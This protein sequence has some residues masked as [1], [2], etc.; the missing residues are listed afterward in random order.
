LSAVGGTLDRTARAV[1]DAGGELRAAWSPGGWIAVG[2]LAVAALVPLALPSS[3]RIDGLADTGYL[4]LAAVGLG[5]A[6]GIGGIP[7]LAQGAFVGVGAVTAAHAVESGWPALGAAV[8]GAAVAGAGG[9]LVGI[10]LVRFRAAYVVAATWLVTWLFSLALDAFPSV[11]GGARGLVVSAKPILGFTPTPT[12][13]YELALGLLVLALLGHWTLARSSF[14][15]SL[16]AAAQRPAAAAALGVAIARLGLAAFAGAAAVGGLAGGLAV[17]LAAVADPD[18][19]GPELSFRLLVAVLV[20]GAATAL[21]PVAGVLVLG[22]LSL[23]ADALADVT[24]AETAR[25]GPMLAAL[26]LVAV[27]TIGSDGIV[28]AAARLRQRRRTSPGPRADPTPVEGAEVAARGLAKRFGGVVALRSFDLDLRTGRIAALIGPNGSGKTTALRLLAGTLSPD[29]GSVSLDRVD[30]TGAP[31]AE[32]ARR[33]LV[34]TLQAGAVFPELTAL[35]NAVVGASLRRRHGGPLR[36]LL[37]TPK[38]REEARLTR[39]R[40]LAALAAVELESRADEPAGRLSGAEQRLLMIASALAT[41]PRVLLVDEPSAGAGPPDLERLARVFRR[42]RHDGLAVLV[43]EHNL[44][45]VRA[46]A[47]EVVVLD[48]GVVL[49]TAAPDEIARDR[50][51]RAAYLGR[52]PL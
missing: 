40:A 48:A 35:E 39:A 18:A 29:A 37:A 15:L 22:A 32:R 52:R 45:L 10:G 49:A 47:D 27:L 11:S 24:G 5:F 46:I 20:G 19:Y 34:R 26:L 4:A 9:V 3:I 8:V 42:L 13:H 12:V 28:P 33:G 17:Q 43:V 41:E 30:A 25:F 31:T 21:G 38:A 16:R 36:A 2:A 23:A 7:S 14:G 50:A 44:R 6:V 1:R 51:V